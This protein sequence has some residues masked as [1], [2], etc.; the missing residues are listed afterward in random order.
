MVRTVT[1]FAA[2]VVVAS[3][4]LARP[5]DATAQRNPLFLGQLHQELRQAKAQLAAFQNAKYAHYS[6][7]RR[8][9]FVPQ[10]AA[11][12]FVEDV[13]GALA[14]EG[15][16]RGA[17]AGPTSVPNEAGGEMALLLLFEDREGHKQYMDDPTTK[18]FL[19]RHG[20]RWDMVRALDVVA[21]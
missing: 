2:G 12:A 11:N 5:G 15:S 14:K 16:V 19:D 9:P 3:L 10:Q 21:K 13:Y 20:R 1:A 6:V 18:R 7:W 4:F 8:R 17:W